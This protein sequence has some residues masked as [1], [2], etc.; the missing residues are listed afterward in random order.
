[1]QW[2]ILLGVG[3][4]CTLI[5]R[6]VLIA[7]AFRI[8]WGWGLGVFLPFGPFLFRR[9]YP[10][11][12]RRAMPFQLVAL[13][14][15]LIYLFAGP[16][17]ALPQLPWATPEEESALTASESAKGFAIEHPKTN[18]KASLAGR[19]IANTR[20]LERLAA[21]DKELKRRKRD[22]LR[23][24]TEGNAQ[25]E[26]DLGDYEEALALANAEKEELASTRH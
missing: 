7:S 25:Y 1:M 22:L 23:S 8:S 26:R 18:K 20:E 14:C 11:D 2:L 24:D 9:K 6:V 4:I 19:R 13:P 16:G 5:A 15:F 21:Q 17:V 3:L 12:A 10:D